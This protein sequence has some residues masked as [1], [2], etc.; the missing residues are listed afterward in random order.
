MSFP[1]KGAV[2]TAYSVGKEASAPGIACPH[3]QGYI[4]V[5]GSNE[6]QTAGLLLFLN[7]LQTV[8]SLTTCPRGR[9]LPEGPLLSYRCQKLCDVL[10]PHT[11]PGILLV[12]EMGKWR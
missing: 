7:C 6:E 5:H 10:V 2:G 11:S 3:G 12:L 9:A 4:I 8:A 1:F